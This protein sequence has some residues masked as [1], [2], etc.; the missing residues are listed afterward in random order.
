MRTS[1]SIFF[2]F[3]IGLGLV[4]AII[5]QPPSLDLSLDLTND[6]L[7]Q[8]EDVTQSLIIF[9]NLQRIETQMNL[10]Q[11]SLDNDDLNNAFQ[12]AFIPHSVTFPVL[13]VDSRLDCCIGETLAFITW[14]T[15]V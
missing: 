3:I 4:V 2:I 10:T 5:L 6:V 1:L 12:H 8:E 13:M 15:H 14:F 7:A 9:T 11:Y